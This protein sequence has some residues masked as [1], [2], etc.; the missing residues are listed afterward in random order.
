MESEVKIK[1]LPFKEYREIVDE[2]F[3]RPLFIE[4]LPKYRKIP[5]GLYDTADQTIYILDQEDMFKLILYH[6]LGHHLNRDRLPAKIL[7][8][9]L[10]LMPL[11]EVLTILMLASTTLMFLGLIETFFQYVTQAIMFVLLVT[12]IVGA[13][14]Y[15]YD[16]Y[17]AEK[18]AF[19]RMEVEEGEE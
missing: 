4:I 16:E 19:E 6:E 8:Y 10:K 2:R 11:W 15:L 14:S 18:Y 7:T 3:N 17:L 9:F 13:Y 1:K 5:L 12:G